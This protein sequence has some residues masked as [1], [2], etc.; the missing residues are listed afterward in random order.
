MFA[1]LDAGGRL[2]WFAPGGRLEVAGEAEYE[3]VGWLLG[4]AL[5]N[6]VLM[7]LALPRAAYSLLLGG[8]PESLDD[9]AD[10][11]PE[12]HKSM[13]ALLAAAAAD[14]PRVRG[15]VRA[16]VDGVVGAD[17]PVFAAA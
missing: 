7:E 2:T 11:A 12:T 14:P 9:L 10:V 6:G 3:L 16:D 15:G 13:A 17:A 1:P 8:T 4:L 5:Y